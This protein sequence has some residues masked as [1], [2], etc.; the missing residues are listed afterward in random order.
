MYQLPILVLMVS[1]LSR[2]KS[3]GEEKEIEFLRR[4]AYIGIDPGKSGAVALIHEE[5]YE[6]FDWPG[7]S[8]LASDI[9]RSW[10]ARYNVVFAVLEK[11][12][13][14]PKQG[15]VSM[16]SLG[17]NLG[18]WQ[19]ILSALCIPYMMPTPRQWQ[20]GL[21]DKKSG[22]D[23]KARSLTTARRLFPN[24]PLDRKKDHG[25][26]DALLLAFWA[27]TYGGIM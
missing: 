8:T 25:R 21:V 3:A 12:S 11:I 24:A 7:D 27:K 2:L 14:M 9:I 6:V 15:V 20:K 16:F 17:Q 23:P 26:A 10:L 18:I 1:R 13:A 19:G 5:G 4:K 22:L